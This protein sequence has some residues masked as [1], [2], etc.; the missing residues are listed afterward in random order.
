MIVEV[1][2]RDSVIE[3]TT[4]A[5]A[6]Q[7]VMLGQGSYSPDQYVP[8]PLTGMMWL[9]LLISAAFVLAMSRTEVIER[10]GE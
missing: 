2:T 6:E 10:G 4:Y 9:A 1:P 5:D 3:M 8:T 7:T